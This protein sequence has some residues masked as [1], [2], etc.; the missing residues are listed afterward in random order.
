MKWRFGMQRRV[1]SL[2]T[3]GFLS[4]VLMGTALAQVP[5]PQTLRVLTHSSFELPAEL[6]AG[7]EKQAGVKLQIVKGGDAGEMLNKLILT[8][9]KPIADVINIK[10]I[11]TGA[12]VNDNFI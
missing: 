4:L 8:R 1:F 5:K 9:A 2:A 11:F 10:L 3:G 7:F 6:L 12:H